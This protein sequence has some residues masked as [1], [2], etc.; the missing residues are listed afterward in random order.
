MPLQ[1]EKVIELIREEKE[2]KGLLITDHLYQHILAL[3]DELYLL[4]D[5]QTHLVKD[6]VA[7]EGFGY[8]TAA[9]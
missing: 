8:V 6:L 2:H 4:A 7:I 9:R 3:A 1:I 5:G